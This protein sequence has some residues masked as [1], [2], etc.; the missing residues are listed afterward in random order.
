LI[1]DRAKPIEDALQLARRK[2]ERNVG[3]LGVFRFLVWALRTQCARSDIP[4]K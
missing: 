3:H 4:V 2:V 1:F